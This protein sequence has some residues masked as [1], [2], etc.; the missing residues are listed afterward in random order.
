[1]LGEILWVTGT[2]QGASEHLEAALAAAPADQE[3]AARVYPKLVYFNAAH[4]PPRARELAEVAVEALDPERAPGALA[5]VLFSRFWIGLLLGEGHRP[6][7][8][9][10]VARA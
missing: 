4:D 7:L 6:E 1:M 2:F 3:L 9:E 8:L 5:S 10:A